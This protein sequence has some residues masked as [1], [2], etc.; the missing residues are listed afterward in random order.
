MTLII[1]AIARQAE[2]QPCAPA[3]TNGEFTLDYQALQQ[4]TLAAAATLVARNRGTTALAL[5]NGPAWAIADLALL[6]AGSPCLPLPGFFSPAQQVHALRNAG[7]DWLLTDRPDYYKPLLE[8]GAIEARREEDI[9][10]GPC[11]AARFALNT[12]NWASQRPAGTAKITY[13]SGTTGTPKGVCLS[14][15]AIHATAASL[16][17]AAQFS[18]GDRHLAL[19]PLST[20]LE[21]VGGL[22]A[23]LLAGACAVLMPLAKVGM[24]G[25]SGLSIDTLITALATQRATTAILI[26]EMLRGLCSALMHGGVRPSTLRFLAV[27][28]ATVSP[29]LLAHARNAGLPVYEGYGLSEC[30]SVVALNTAATYRSGSVGRPLPHVQI[31]IGDEH[32]IL[33]R[34]AGFLGYAGEDIQTNDW[35]PTGDCGYFDAEGFLFL[36]G[37]RKNIFITSYGRNISPD[38][39]ESELLAHDAIAQAWV[40]GEARPW[41][42]AVIT[43]RTGASASA[44]EAAVQSANGLLPDYARVRHWISSVEPFSPTNGELTPNGRLRRDALATRYGALLDQLYMEDCR[45]LL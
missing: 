17:S 15:G 35:Y 33:V 14:E 18:S 9:S 34:G 10:L 25:A 41:N 19:L 3:L 44:A 43:V 36:T 16:A 30:A 27:G 13:T 2:I 7:A 20:L 24:A 32:E 12:N 29:T 22:Y 40:H 23:P 6:A 37:R 1:S 8:T 42:C 38:W 21:N 31:R 11:R 4:A 5:D 39:V 45:E 26:P 28:G